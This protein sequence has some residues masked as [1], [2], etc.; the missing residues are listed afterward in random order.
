MLA[1]HRARGAEG[2]ILVTKV[3]DP[4][5]YGVVVQDGEGLIDRF[6]EKPKEFVGDKINAGEKKESGGVTSGLEDC[7]E[8]DSFRDWKTN[9]SDP[10]F[11]K[12]RSRILH[13]PAG[14][15]VLNPEVISRIPLKPTSIEREVFPTIAADKRLYAF[16][17]EGYWMDVGQPKARNV[18]HCRTLKAHCRT[19][20][21]REYQ[22]AA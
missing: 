22:A 21:D 10:S 1:F 4:S 15:Y 2:T 19:L 14:I 9:L 12:I 17:L 20:L 8:K 18:R 5:K 11:L 16:A 6:V 7:S 13:P 3:E